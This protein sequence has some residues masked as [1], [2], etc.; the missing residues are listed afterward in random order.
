MGISATSYSGHPI[1]IEVSA[2]YPVLTF[3]KFYHAKP[4]PSG[5]LS[6]CFFLYFGEFVTKIVSRGSLD[7]CKF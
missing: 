5:S 2:I 7:G 6:L 4:L 1:L 3:K